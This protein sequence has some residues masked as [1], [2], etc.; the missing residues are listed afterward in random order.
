MPTFMRNKEPTN[1]YS[2]ADRQTDTHRDKDATKKIPASYSWCTNN[3]TSHVTYR[4]KILTDNLNCLWFQADAAPS[5][6]DVDNY[7]ASVQSLSALADNH[8]VTSFPLSAGTPAQFQHVP[9]A[10]GCYYPQ[11]H[12]QPTFHAPYME[13]GL[14][15]NWRHDGLAQRYWNADAHAA[16]GHDWF[17][18]RSHHHAQQYLGTESSA[19]HR[20]W[21]VR[22][23]PY[24]T[25]AAT[26]GYGADAVGVVPSL[27][28]STAYRYAYNGVDQRAPAYVAQSYSHSLG[29]A[30]HNCIR[31]MAYDAGQPACPTPQAP[32]DAGAYSSYQT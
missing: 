17:K 4:Y 13:A 27:S 31:Q 5:R 2:C 23:H 10:A 30:S 12:R 19:W 18:H 9:P 11:A 3:Y 24:A 20:G 29:D 28:T 8:T 6:G 16:D 26:A 25:A 14:P 22:Y 21:S 7:M 32:Y 1:V 15:V